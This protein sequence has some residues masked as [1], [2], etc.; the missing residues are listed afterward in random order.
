[1]KSEVCWSVAQGA[2]VSWRAPRRLMVSAL[3]VIGAAWCGVAD[4]QWI[5]RD[6]NRQMHS[7]DLPPPKDIPEANIVQRP[8]QR[9]APPAPTPAASA[10]ASAAS[11]SPLQVEVES[12]RA[13]EAQEQQ[14]RR[15]EEDQ[16][17]NA[18]RAENCQNAR[19][20]LTALD[21]GQR[22]VRLNDQGERE[23]LDDKGRAESS[24]RARTVIARDC[25]R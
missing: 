10:A 1:M 5:W 11:A 16:Q 2:P 7:S 24:Q 4:A 18:A 8:S 13:R 25:S 14:A 15:A 6:A 22:I 21:G 3:L 12:R 20:E 19:R 23:F 17:R 9:P